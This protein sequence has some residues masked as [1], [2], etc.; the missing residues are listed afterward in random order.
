MTARFKLLLQ[1]ALRNLVASRMNIAIGLLILSGTMFFVVFGALLQSISKS[2][3]RS[4]VGS[5]SGHIQVYNSTSK[6]KVALYGDLT[7]GAPDLTPMTNFPQVKAALLGLPQIAA[8]VPMGTDNAVIT[9]GNIVD[10]TLEKLRDLV[11]AKTQTSLREDL[12]ALPSSELDKRIGI[13]VA[14][15]RQIIKVLSTTALRSKE[16][17]SD[18]AIDKDAAAALARVSEDAFWNGFQAHP[19]EA[20]EYLENRI[21]PQVT[22]AQLLYIGYLGTDLDAFRRV[23]D[24]MEIVDGT[25]VPTGHRGFLIPKFLYE[26]QLKLKQARRLDLIRDALADG[27]RITTDPDLR[28]WVK[29][30]REQTSDILLQLDAVETERVASGLRAL[31]HSEEADLGALLDAFFNTNDDNFRA[32]YQYFYDKMAPVLTLYRVRIGDI[33]T[34]KSFSKSGSAQTVN[35]KVYGTFAFKGIEKSPLA[36]AMSMMDLM[37]FRDL[38]GYM[39]TDKKEELA[40]IKEATGAKQVTRANAESELFGADNTGAT[41]TVDSRT[42]TADQELAGHNRL[43]RIDDLLNRTYTEEEIES[44][45]ALSAAIILRDP[46]RIQSTIGQID[47]LSMDQGLHVAAITWQ[48]AAGTLGQLIVFLQGIVLFIALI[49]FLVALVIINNAMM[50]AAIQ[51]TQVFGTLRAIGAQKRTV[52]TMVLLETV[53]LAS[54]FGIL[55]VAAGAGIVALIHHFGIPAPNEMAYFFFSGPKLLP[56]L[57][58]GNVVAAL[59]LTLLVAIF[60]TIVPAF[61]A[62]RV[63]PVRAMQADE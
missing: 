27:K 59:G 45:V 10:V 41:A 54:F 7:G 49:I 31:L 25:A 39:T 50:M 34:I 60:S 6:D 35:V 58:V 37:S 38:Y 55:G 36:G 63:A 43:Q 57:T 48:T 26:D 46:T 9:T 29:E 12:N 4:V 18:D 52:L 3:A 30:N 15:V 14:H 22:D 61:I 62:T 8:V 24:R 47:K 11:R 19:N 20:L 2:M 42:I 5:I 53:V 28:R 44:G 1:L 32:R 33:L 23:F 56:E 16:I 17:L 13:Q 21:A 40:R 51:R